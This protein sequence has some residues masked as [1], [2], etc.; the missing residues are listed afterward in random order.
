MGTLR[1]LIGETS[2]CDSLLKRIMVIQTSIWFMSLTQVGFKA[3][4]YLSIYN[5]SEIGREN[6]SIRITDT[7]NKE[8]MVEY[9]TILKYK[10]TF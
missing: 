5:M 9:Q 3:Q 1:R 6:E 7:K 8:D 4:N 10:F 2:A